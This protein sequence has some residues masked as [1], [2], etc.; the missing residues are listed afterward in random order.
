MRLLQDFL[1]KNGGYYLSQLVNWKSDTNKL[2]QHFKEYSIAVSLPADQL[3]LRQL[4]ALRNLLIHAEK[5]VPFYTNLFEEYNFRPE[6]IS[7]IDDISLLPPL[8]RIHLQNQ[9]EQ[10]TSIDIENRKTILNQTGGSTGNPVKLYQ[11]QDYRLRGKAAEMVFNSVAG[12]SI[13][14]RTAI[15]WGSDK[16][17]K[18]STTFK[19]KLH[20]YFTNYRH[21]SAYNMSDESMMKYFTDMQKF[22][23]DVLIGYAESLNIYASFVLT[24]NLSPQ[25]PR[26]SI[27]SSA[28]TLFADMRKQIHKAFRVSVFDRYGSREVGTIASECPI[29]HGLHVNTLNQI[30]Q[31]EPDKLDPKILRIL[32]TNLR[33][34]ATP[35]IR[36]EIGD[37]SSGWSTKSS[38]SLN[39]PSLKD[40]SGRITSIITTIDGRRI[41]GAKF[42]HI[43]F[44]YMGLASYQFCQ[45]TLSDYLLMIVPNKNFDENCLNL[46]KHDILKVVGSESTVNIRIVQNIPLT[47]S[48]KHLFTVSKV[49]PENPALEILNNEANSEPNPKQNSSFEH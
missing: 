27:I 3:E 13:G 46:I 32:V 41:Y 12:W 8:Q 31:L 34:Y 7:C 30:V 24:N 14:C 36:Y 18:P 37:T 43:L 42:R 29:H 40:I 19:G 47:S 11:D 33:N 35:L 49:L 25:F 44:N 21:Y 6:S 1:A 39:S 48:G 16:D 20:N 15:L 10:L 9:L 17:L 5:N 23:P 38:C 2:F 26:K 28:G 4:I 22:K 45:N